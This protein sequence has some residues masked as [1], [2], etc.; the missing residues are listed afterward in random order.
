MEKAAL[1][2]IKYITNP[3]ALT[4]FIVLIAGYTYVKI[5]SGNNKQNNSNNIKV[6][7]RDNDVS[8][9]NQSIN[10]RDDKE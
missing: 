10:K 4:A 3:Y 8:D 6:S 9:I 2:A 5:R 7:G 1:E